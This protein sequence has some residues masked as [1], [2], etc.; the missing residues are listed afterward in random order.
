MTQRTE[1]S[2]AWHKFIALA[3]TASLGLGAWGISTI[4]DQSVQMASFA[5]QMRD[6][7]DQL[8]VIPILA[9]QVNNNTAANAK[10]D[11]AIND[12]RAEM[13]RDHLVPGAGR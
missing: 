11:Q 4:H 8:N 1:V 12:M 13:Q 7:R 6:M 2:P 10:Q 9:Q 3:V 5:A